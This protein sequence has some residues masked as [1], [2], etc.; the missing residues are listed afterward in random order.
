MHT[1][2]VDLVD[3]RMMTFETTD[4]APKVVLKDD[5]EHVEKMH[6]LKAELS[7]LDE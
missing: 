4:F 2:S 6:Q 7:T 3:Y 1:G 5:P